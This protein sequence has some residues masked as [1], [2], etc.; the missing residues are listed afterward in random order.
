MNSA[1]LST[2]A[3]CM[4]VH[5]YRR[6]DAWVH[7]SADS[8]RPAAT[9]AIELAAADEWGGDMSN[10]GARKEFFDLQAKWI[11]V[12]SGALQQASQLVRPTFTTT[13]RAPQPGTVA[14]LHA[15]PVD[16]GDIYLN[17]AYVATVRQGWAEGTYTNRPVRLTLNM[18]VNTLAIKVT[19]TGSPYG[20]G[21]IASVTNADGS[22]TFART[23]GL[24]TYTLEVIGGQSKRR[25]L[26]EGSTRGAS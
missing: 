3:C 18:G 4:H 13:L 6:I 20:G 10:V 23:S 24:W 8:H 26:A 7:Q 22:S 1:R 25:A 16:V 14:L 12:H 17:D 9:G 15:I 11:W 5:I 21:L 2:A 19:N